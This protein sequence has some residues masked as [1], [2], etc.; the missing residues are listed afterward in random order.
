MYKERLF[1]EIRDVFK[2]KSRASSQWILIENFTREEILNMTE[3]EFIEK[4]KSISTPW[5]HN[6]RVM[7]KVLKFYDKVIERWKKNSHSLI[8]N[9]IW[10]DSDFYIL[11]DIKYKQ[12]HYDL[13]IKQMENINEKI[14]KIMSILKSNLY[15]IP[16]FKWINDNEI[17]IFLWELGNWIYTMTKNELM[18]FVWWHP[19]NYTSWWWH[20][21]KASKFSNKDSI[22]KKFVYIRMYWFNMQNPSFRLYK[23]LLWLYYWIKSE[24][25]SIIKIKNKRKIEAKSGY[26]LLE[27]IHSCYKYSCNFD[28]DRFLNSTITPLISTMIDKWISKE[29]IKTEILGIYKEIPSKINFHCK[30]T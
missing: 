30:Q 7:E 21:V 15:F 12:Q 4:Y 9:L 8:D 19:N 14:W 10:Q 18:W 28:E 25:E 16:S 5:Q 22:I 29:S 23:K 11:E 24:T 2:I 26:K 17:W 3:S 1:P 6:K 13:I 20:I 27:I